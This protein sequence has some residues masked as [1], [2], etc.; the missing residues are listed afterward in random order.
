MDPLEV[1]FLSRP[2]RSLARVGVRS[3]RSK[4]ASES[5]P[6]DSSAGASAANAPSSV[7][8][9]LVAPRGAPLGFESPSNHVLCGMP[10]KKTFG[11]ER[12]IRT[13]AA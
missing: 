10:T 3:L 7:A 12:G 11:G 13:Y 8:F 5:R 1:G 2:A 6:K 9:S 4:R